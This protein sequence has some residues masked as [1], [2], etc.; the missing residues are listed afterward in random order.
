LIEWFY[1]A[2]AVPTEIACRKVMINHQLCVRGEQECRGDFLSKWQE[3]EV[4]MTK[5]ASLNP[6]HAVAASLSWAEGVHE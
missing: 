5:N 4:G 3:S 2:S 6:V 1:V